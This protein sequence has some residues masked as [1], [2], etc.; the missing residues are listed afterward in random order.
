DIG[1]ELAERRGQAFPREG[2]QP[3]LILVGRVAVHPDELV[4]RRAGAHLLEYLARKFTRPLA[5]RRGELGDDEDVTGLALRALGL[6]H[7]DDV[8]AEAALDDAADRARREREG[9]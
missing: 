7:L 2:A 9:D 6:L 4:D 5:I 8:E 3:P 1:Q